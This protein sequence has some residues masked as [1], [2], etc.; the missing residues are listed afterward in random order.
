MWKG[1]SGRGGV[2][3]HFETTTTWGVAWACHRA[4]CSLIGDSIEQNP[5]LSKSRIRRAGGPAS[6][7]RRA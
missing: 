7:S 3:E 4:G 5:L 6:N 2:D 1:I